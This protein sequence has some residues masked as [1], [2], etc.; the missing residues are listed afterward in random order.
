M[1]GSA[2][3]QVGPVSIKRLDEA[4]SVVCNF[5]LSVAA[6]AVVRADSSIRYT[7]MLLV[8]NNKQL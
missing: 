2:L 8:V 4:E 6:R 3:G 1:L 7:S 5:Y